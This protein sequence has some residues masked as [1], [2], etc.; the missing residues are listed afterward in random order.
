MNV[1]VKDV[2]PCRKVLHVTMP[3]GEG[4]AKAYEAALRPYLAQGA[5]QGFRK[6]KVPRAVIERQFEKG[7]LEDFS[8]QVVQQGYREAVSELKLSVVSIVKVE[9]EKASV[10]A[11]AEF[12]VTV[13]VQ[14]EFALP[15][16]TDV[17]IKKEDIAVSEEQ[18]E[19]QVQ[20]MLES[21]ANFKEPQEGDVAAVRDAVKVD[22]RGTVDG[23]QPLAEAVPDAAEAASAEG[24]WCMAGDQGS[25]IPGMSEALVGASAGKEVEFSTTLPESHANEALRSR[26]VHYTVTV[27]EVRRREVPAMDEAFFKRLGVADEAALKTAMRQRLEAERMAYDARRRHDEMAQYLIRNTQIEVPESL[28]E[29]ETQ[30]SVK[31]LVQGAMRQGMTKEELGGHQAEV[32]ETAKAQAAGRIK[33]SL[34]M[35]KI[36]EAEKLEVSPE[37]IDK[38]IAASAQQR[39]ISVDAMKKEIAKDRRMGEIEFTLRNRKAAQWVLE[40][41]KEV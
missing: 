12:D 30:E 24:A 40:H 37:E 34:I 2:G 19:G 13:D 26:T 21:M 39:G 9:N 18:V 41:A 16:Y 22:Y 11:G 36:A 14:P 7:I 27:K 23:G 32:L 20:R 15:K 31:E 35:S 1:E 38:A 5:V 25:A 4:I 29:Q 6:G 17:P 33:F 8:Q 10:A 28:L 3:A